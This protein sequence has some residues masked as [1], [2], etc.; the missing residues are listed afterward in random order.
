MVNRSRTAGNLG[1]IGEG[2]IWGL[3]KGIGENQLIWFIVKTLINETIWLCTN[4]LS[5]HDV[6]TCIIS[7]YRRSSITFEI[8]NHWFISNTSTSIV[9]HIDTKK[10][11]TLKRLFNI[12]WLQVNTFILWLH[13]CRIKSFKNIN[14]ILRTMTHFLLTV[15]F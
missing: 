4:T 7:Y 11:M 8:F 1:S 3:V 14:I 5:L 12:K 10:E 6:Y 2:T 9:T 15:I 13:K